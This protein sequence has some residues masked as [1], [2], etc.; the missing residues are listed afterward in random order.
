MDGIAVAEKRSGGGACEDEKT[1]WCLP[2]R[3]DF[4]STESA[5]AGVIIREFGFEGWTIS[6]EGI[7]VLIVNKHLRGFVD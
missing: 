6:G 1:G 3:R 2:I 5:D 4:R 7:T